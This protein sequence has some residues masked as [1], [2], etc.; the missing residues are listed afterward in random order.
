MKII[1]SDYP[2]DTGQEMPSLF[3]AGPT[4]RR[5]EVASWRP[6]ALRILEELKFD[7]KVFVPE[8]SCPSKAVDFNTQCEWEHAHLNAAT[9][10]V[11]WVPRSMSGMPALT[12]NI[13]MGIW[14]D[15]PK[16]LYGRPDWAEHCSYLDWLYTRYFNVVGRPFGV[17]DQPFNDLRALLTEAITQAKFCWGNLTGKHYAPS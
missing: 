3:A 4:P 5:P 12:T 14:H 2:Q 1:Y 8:W 17:P 6:N 10:I 13:E 15:S 9:V 11:F 16:L 7:G